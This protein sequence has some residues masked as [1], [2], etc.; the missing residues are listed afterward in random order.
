MPKAEVEI[1]VDREA[2]TVTVTCKTNVAIGVAL[3][4]DAVFEDNYIDLL[5]GETRVIPYTT[6]DGFDKIDLYGYNVDMI[7]GL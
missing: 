2:K 4:G 5:Q 6:L 1:S 3:D 7:N